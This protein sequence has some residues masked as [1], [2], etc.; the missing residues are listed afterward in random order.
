ME[1]LRKAVGAAAA[2]DSYISAHASQ[3]PRQR[4]RAFLVWCALEEE[5]TRREKEVRD[6]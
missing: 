1:E 2:V 3:Y 5:L 4:D 6:E